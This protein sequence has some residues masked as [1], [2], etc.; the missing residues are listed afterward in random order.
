MVKASLSCRPVVT[1]AESYYTGLTYLDED[2]EFC[3]MVDSIH[4]KVI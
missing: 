4:K 3:A 2:V 1:Y